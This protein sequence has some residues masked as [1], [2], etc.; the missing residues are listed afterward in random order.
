M[1]ENANGLEEQY[2]YSDGTQ[3]VQNGSV[4][5]Y[6]K[7]EPIEWK[8]LTTDYNGTGKKLLLAK[9]CLVPFRF[10]GSSNDYAN[11]EI[12]TYLNDGFLNSAFTTELQARIADT[13]VINNA[14]STNPDL[15]ATQWNSGNNSNASDTPT[16]DKLFLLSEQE[17]TKSEYG[18]TGYDVYGAGNSR[19]R[20][21]TDFAKAAGAFQGSLD[22]EGNLWWLRSPYYNATNKVYAVE[23]NGAAGFVPNV[24]DGT[25]GLVPALCLTE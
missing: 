16:T 20:F 19:I 23:S 10:D 24:T 2:K 7:V 8:I 12:R 17:V 4:Y 21:P 18:F 14:R 1:A 13:T 9:K 5:R 25:Y 15:H 6:F 22:G 3:P 11:S